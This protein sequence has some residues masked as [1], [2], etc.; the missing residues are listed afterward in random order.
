MVALIIVG[1]KVGHRPAAKPQ[2]APVA[3]PATLPSVGG[4]PPLLESGE[5]GAPREAARAA[6][7]QSSRTVLATPGEATRGAKEER[8]IL[9][10]ATYANKKQAEAMQKRLRAQHLRAVIIARKTKG[11]TLYQVQV[12][13]IAGAKAAEDAA[14]RIKAQEKI[15]P[16]VVKLASK[17]AGAHNKRPAR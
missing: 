2:P 13:P 5:A 7:G 15:T 3:A 12:G 14:G 11:K 8:Y 16:K 10:A 17:T 4:G 1:V 6:A 9:V